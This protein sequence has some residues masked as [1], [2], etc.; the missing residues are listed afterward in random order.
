[1]RIDPYIRK[2][3]LEISFNLLLILLGLTLVFPFLW[4]IVK[5]INYYGIYFGL[6]LSLVGVLLCGLWIVLLAVLFFAMKTLIKIKSLRFYL[7]SD[8]FRIRHNNHEWQIALNKIKY[9]LGNTRGI[10]LVW[11]D[12]DKIKTFFLKK[13]Y[14][15]KKSYRDIITFFAECNKYQDHVAENIKIRNQLGLNNILRRNKL[16][17]E[18]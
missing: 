18:L 13:S 11:E 3:N 1:M 12:N 4:G 16:E 9:A 15:S 5:L 17:K 7:D 2:I 8:F 6:L 10:M 14:F